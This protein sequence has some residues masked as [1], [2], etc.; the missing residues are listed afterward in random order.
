MGDESVLRFR[1][2]GRSRWVERGWWWREVGGA[3]W[4]VVRVYVGSC[5]EF[6]GGFAC[7]RVQQDM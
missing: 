4:V 1:W 6:V 7:K 2:V 3:G 5:V